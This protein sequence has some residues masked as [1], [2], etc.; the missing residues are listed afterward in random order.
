ML[1]VLRP[2]NATISNPGVLHGHDLNEA[3]KKN[4]IDWLRS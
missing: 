1:V 2:N 4:I 3:E